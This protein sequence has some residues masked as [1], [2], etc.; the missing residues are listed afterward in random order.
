M[1]SQ[2]W[3]A[4]LPGLFWGFNL[5]GTDTKGPAQ[6]QGLTIIVMGTWQGSGGGQAPPD[7]LVEMQCSP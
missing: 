2:G 4:P 1:F 3:D 5:L 6:C 7:G